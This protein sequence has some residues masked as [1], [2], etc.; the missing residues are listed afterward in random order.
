M[1]LCWCG[2]KEFS[3][4][5]RFHL[6]CSRCGTLVSSVRR[7]EPSQFNDDAESI[8]GREYWFTHQRDDLNLPD[9]LQRARKDLPERCAYWL[10]T[11]LKYK[12]PPGRAL[13]LGCGHGGFILCSAS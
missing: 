12:I 10:N 5:S 7:V 8:Y 1:P 9:I 4:F 11:V 6:K 3:S 13:E 2:S